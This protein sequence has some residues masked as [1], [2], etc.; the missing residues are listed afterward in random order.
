M[1]SFSKSQ[2]VRKPAV[3]SKGGIVASQH[4]IASEIG[5]D[6]LAAGG[7][8]IDAAVAV[9]FAIGVLE[10]WMSGPAGGGAMMVWSRSDTAR[11]Y[12]FASRVWSC[13]AMMNDHSHPSAWL[14]RELD[15]L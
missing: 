14:W 1:H 5:A 2:I 12:P 13:I 6:I 10:P 15:I 8:A 3:S 4:R 11:P 9:S 7:D